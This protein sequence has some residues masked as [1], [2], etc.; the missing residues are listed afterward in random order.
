[1]LIALPVNWEYILEQGDQ[2]A[3]FDP[4]SQSTL[5]LNIIKAI[6]PKGIDSEE[7]IKSITANQQFAIT[8][9]GYLLTSPFYSESNEGDENIT[10]ISWRLVNNSGNEKIIAVVTY[11]L[12]SK[13][14]DSAKENEI[15]NLIEN[16]LKHAELSHSREFPTRV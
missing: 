3:C 6:P 15:F 13:E 9:K 14:K 8:T 4:K 1:L 5:R 16:S 12:L 11:T 7:K 2:E 10:L